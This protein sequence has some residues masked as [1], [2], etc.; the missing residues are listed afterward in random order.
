MQHPLQRRA[1]RELAHRLGQ[2]AVADADAFRARVAD[3]GG[4]V[5]WHD[6]DGIYRPGKLMLTDYAW[7]H[8]T[9]WAIKADDE[10]NYLQDQFD[11][12][13]VYAQLRQRKAR[14]GD[15]VLEHIEFMKFLG[16]MVPQGLTLVRAT[17]AAEL[18]EITAF[19]ES[20]GIWTADPHTHFLDED[21]RWNGQPILDAKAAWDPHGLLNPGHLKLLEQA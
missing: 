14:Y 21:V 12:E 5:T 2:F 7:N 17:S 6:P 3:A 1:D 13:R 9:L 4:K 15:R 8:T 16:R 18:Q 20:I 10:L 11:P 19:C